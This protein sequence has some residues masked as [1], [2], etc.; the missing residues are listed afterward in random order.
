MLHRDNF[1]RFWSFVRRRNTRT[2]LL[3]ESHVISLDS[4]YVY[5]HLIR[6]SRFHNSC[7]NLLAHKSWSALILLYVAIRYDHTSAYY[8]I[9]INTWIE[10]ANILHMFVRMF[11]S[12]SMCG[13][14]QLYWSQG[15]MPKKWRLYLTIKKWPRNERRA[16]ILNIYRCLIKLRNHETSNTSNELIFLFD[17]QVI[18]KL[19]FR[20]KAVLGLFWYVVD[21][22]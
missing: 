20:E 15:N 6:I 1:N 12:T 14:W 22:T 11:K 19:S 7:F 4:D 8:I 21:L 9:L 18:L 16:S 17:C 13:S 3:W 10:A 5:C 2:I